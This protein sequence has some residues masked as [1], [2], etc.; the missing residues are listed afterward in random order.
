MKVVFLDRDGVVN[1]YPGDRDY[2]KSLEEFTFL[3]RS[4]E[5]IACLHKAGFQLYVISNQ[6]GVSKGL[7]SQATLDKITENMLIGVR[8][9]GG[10]INGVYYCTH[11]PD[12]DCLCRKPKTGLIELAKKEHSLK[13]D[14]AFFI[15]DSMFDVKTAKA[16]GMV[17]ILVLSGKEKLANRDNWEVKPDFIFP[18]LFEAAQFILKG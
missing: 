7:Y 6:A 10:E 13:L 15:G 17:S 14:H 18:D 3:P 2:V 1:K 16:S 8:A 4:K 12:E 5:A 9:S 11:R